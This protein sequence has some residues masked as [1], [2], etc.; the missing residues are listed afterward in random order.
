MVGDL[1]PGGGLKCCWGGEQNAAA[2]VIRQRSGRAVDDVPSGFTET[3]E[4]TAG[5]RTAVLASGE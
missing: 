2:Y 4:M 3:A 1:R 5:A